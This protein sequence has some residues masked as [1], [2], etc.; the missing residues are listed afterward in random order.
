MLTEVAVVKSQRHQVT[1]DLLSMND[2]LTRY[3]SCQYPEVAPIAPGSLGSK[4]LN[5]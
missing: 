2:L 5:V 3:P 1:I 4:Q